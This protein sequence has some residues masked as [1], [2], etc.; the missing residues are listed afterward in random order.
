MVVVNGWIER[1]A[2]D[3]VAAAFHATTVAS[4]G[5]VTDSVLVGPSEPGS[6][7][8]RVCSSH[9]A[10]WPGRDLRLRARAVAEHR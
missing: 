7:P 5:T 9:V 4:A 8:T 1:F 3:R 10:A 2:R 6:A